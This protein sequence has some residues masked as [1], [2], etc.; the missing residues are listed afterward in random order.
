M[1]DVD[2]SMVDTQVIQALDVLP[3]VGKL[4]YMTIA[5]YPGVAG[6]SLAQVKMLTHLHHTGSCTVGEVASAC[7]VSMSAASELI[8][9]L[10]E[11]DLVIRGVNPDDRRQVLLAPTAEARRL[12]DEIREMRSRQVRTALDRL[13]PQHR[14]A[15]APVLQALAATLQEEL[16]SG[17]YSRPDRS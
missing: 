10:V 13:A 12:G 15:F 1:G 9:R 14:A 11:D 8:D 3:S 5:R 16:D 2:E 7:G 6:R 4:L 17:P